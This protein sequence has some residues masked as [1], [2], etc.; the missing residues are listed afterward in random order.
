LT[1]ELFD[2]RSRSRVA[3]RQFEASA[4]TAT[5]DSA[6]AAVALSRTVAQVF[7]ALVPWLEGELQLAAARPA[8]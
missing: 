5:A 4:P 6:A 8:P 1:V 3:H 2:R 7:D